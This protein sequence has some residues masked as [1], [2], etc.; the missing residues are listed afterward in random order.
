LQIG[1]A[2]LETKAD[3]EIHSKVLKALHKIILE[4][5]REP[6]LEFLN[7]LIL[8]DEYR[9]II[10]SPEAFKNITQTIIHYLD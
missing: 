5:E 8:K 9:D 1:I 4:E 3:S 7:D 6:V 10:S 2:T